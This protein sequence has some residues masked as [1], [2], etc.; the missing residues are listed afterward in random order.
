MLGRT[1]QPYRSARAPTYAFFSS[2]RP[3]MES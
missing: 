1:P 3:F 2:R